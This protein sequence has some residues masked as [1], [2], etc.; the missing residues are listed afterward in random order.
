[1][2]LHPTSM[3]KTWM[4]LLALTALTVAGAQTLEPQTLMTT[5]GETLLEDNLSAI[6]KDWKAGKGTWK[7][8]DGALQGSEVVAQKHAATYRRALPFQ[9][10]VIQFQFRLDGAKQITFS[11]NDATGHLARVLVQTKGFQARKDDHDHK[12]DDKAVMFND[13]KTPLEAG[14]WY[15]MVIELQG[16]E[17]LARLTGDANETVAQMKVSLGLQAAIAG[18]KAN[19][20]LTVSGSSASFKNLKI[21]NATQNPDWA[22]TKRTLEAAL[23]R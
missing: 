21:F 6:S 19:I 10:A 17:M 5:R 13:V 3:K 20:G 14:R 11:I 4:S 8:V 1:M 18:P 9:N 16:Q 22:N 12:G 2:L 7:M 23:K 15:T